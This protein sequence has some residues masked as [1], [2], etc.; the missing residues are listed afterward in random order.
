MKFKTRN[1]FNN[2]KTKFAVD[3]GVCTFM[4]KNDKG[5]YTSKSCPGCYS[6][7]LLNVYPGLRNKLEEIDGGYPV[8]EDFKSD[9]I[10]FC[11]HFNARATIRLNRRSFRQCSLESLRELARNIS[12]ED[13]RP[14][15]KIGLQVMGKHHSDPVNKWL[16]DVD[17]IL[18]DDPRVGEII[19]FVENIDQGS[20]GKRVLATIPSRT[21]CHLIVT[22]FNPNIFK[23]EYPEIEIIKDSPTNIYIP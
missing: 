23:K 14:V 8:M 22:G 5:N 1:I 11:E 4:E 17:G 20:K 13:Y 7:R 9:I 19:Q 12:D 15:D 2:R 10:T 3:F 21:G 18:A 6:A 16:L